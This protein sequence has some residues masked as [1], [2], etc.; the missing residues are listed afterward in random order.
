VT[1]VLVAIPI[2]YAM[3]THKQLLTAQQMMAAQFR[4]LLV[5]LPAPAAHMQARRSRASC[6]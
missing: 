2:Y 1:I 5:P 4:P 3:Q 6:D